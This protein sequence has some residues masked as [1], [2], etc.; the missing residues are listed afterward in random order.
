MIGYPICAD[1]SVLFKDLTGRLRRSV[2]KNVHS[3]NGSSKYAVVSSNS[4]IL[5]T[6]ESHPSTIPGI[7]DSTGNPSVVSCTSVVSTIIK[8]VVVPYLS[9]SGNGLDAVKSLYKG[10][11]L[12]GPPGTHALTRS[13]ILSC[14]TSI[15]Q[16]LVKHMP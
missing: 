10:V 15:L 9:Y 1:A 4:I 6:S 13:S 5:N 11:L 16:A 7:S 14:L 2:I 3:T 8:K 12:V